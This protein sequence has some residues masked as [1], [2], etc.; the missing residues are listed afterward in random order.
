[1]HVAAVVAARRTRHA[2]IVARHIGCNPSSLMTNTWKIVMLSFATSVALAVGGSAHAAPPRIAIR[3]ELPGRP[4]AVSV[5]T[6]PALS[7]GRCRPG[8]IYLGG[9]ICRVALGGARRQQA[10]RHGFVF[11][12]DVRRL[13]RPPER[14]YYRFHR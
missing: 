4:I 3:P 7:P 9:G 12:R 1:M 13:S 10:A 2:A 8:Q 5:A 6:Q 14:F 11:H